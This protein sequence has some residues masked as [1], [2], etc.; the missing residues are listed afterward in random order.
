MRISA[1]VT[2]SN[3]PPR[4]LASPTESHCSKG[5]DIGAT[6]QSR[7]CTIIL[8]ESFTAFEVLD[9]IFLRGG[10]LKQIKQIS[11]PRSFDYKCVWMLKAKGLE[12]LEYYNSLTS[13]LWFDGSDFWSWH[14]PFVLLCF[15]CFSLLKELWSNL[16]SEVASGR[17]PGGSH[18]QM[19]SDFMWPNRHA[20]RNITSFQDVIPSNCHFLLSLRCSCCCG[21]YEQQAITAS[22]VSCVQVRS[23]G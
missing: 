5:S 11:F 13:P 22:G 20:S 2:C 15:V 7:L 1:G 8:L 3:P 23:Q 18:L 6:S 9:I 21:H 19:M 4:R 14:I 16:P 12:S 10:C 17:I